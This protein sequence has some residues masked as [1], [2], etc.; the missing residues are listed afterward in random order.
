MS[1]TE[2]TTGRGGARSRAAVNWVRRRSASF[3]SALRATAFWVAV[4]LPAVYLPLLF[5][6]D[7][8]AVSL[9]SLLLAVHVATVLVGAGH[10]P[11]S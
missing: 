5:V 4:V 2:T 10:E 1:E 9:V 7:P 3:A 6:G 11:G 8:W